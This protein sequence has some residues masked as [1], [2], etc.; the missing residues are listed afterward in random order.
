MIA[1]ITDRNGFIL[2]TAASDLPNNQLIVND[3]LVDD[4]ESG[5]KT[6]ELTLAATKEV[7]ENCTCGNY[8]MAYNIP[9]TIVTSSLF[10][11]TFLTTIVA[12]S[13]IFSSLYM[14]PLSDNVFSL[15]RS[16]HGVDS[17]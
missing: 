7:R 10:L 17:S 5:V 1:Y 12:L 16:T 3:I 6:L 15:F 14:P 13:F 11:A 2:L 8:V 4:L 9:F